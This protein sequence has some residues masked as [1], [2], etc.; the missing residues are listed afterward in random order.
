MKTSDQELAQWNLESGSQD[1]WTLYY[2]F[3][4]LVPPITPIGLLL[5]PVF[6]WKWWQGHKK[7]KAGKAMNAAA[8]RPDY[9]RPTAV[10]TIFLP[11]SNR[12]DARHTPV[13]PWPPTQSA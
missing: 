12:P 7:V 13:S 3:A 4:L 10:D 11:Y 9:V 2:W 8:N 1:K 5:T 6:A